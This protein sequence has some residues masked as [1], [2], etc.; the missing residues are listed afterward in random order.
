MG[1]TPGDYERNLEAPSCHCRPP[2][3]G[4][5]LSSHNKIITHTFGLGRKKLGSKKCKF[6]FSFWWRKCE[7]NAKTPDGMHVFAVQD[8]ISQSCQKDGANAK[9]RG[10]DRCLMTAYSRLTLH[11]MSS[12]CHYTKYTAHKDTKR[13]VCAVIQHTRQ[14]KIPNHNDEH[15]G[16]AKTAAYLIK[17]TDRA[18]LHEREI[19]AGRM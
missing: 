4:V 6:V 19:G 17:Q 9:K 13:Q 3:R 11:L 18:V 15:C 16:I 5:F 1:G 10:L 14:T 7:K 2:G 8:F 12:M